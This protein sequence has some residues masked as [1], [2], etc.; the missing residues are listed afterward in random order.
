MHSSERPGS[1][2]CFEDAWAELEKRH[3]WRI[4]EEEARQPELNFSQL[5]Y[6]WQDYDNRFA[7]EFRSRHNLPAVIAGARDDWD[8]LLKLRHWTFTHLRFGLVPS[9]EMT[10]P[11]PTVIVE[12]SLAGGTFYCTHFAH[13]FV[14]A[15]AAMGYP[16]RKISVDCDHSESEES[17]QHGIADVW[18]NRFRKWVA[19]DS[20]FDAHY[21]ADGIPLNTE[22]IG[23]RW[24]THRGEGVDA[25]IGPDSRRV[26]RARGGKRDAP[27]ACS[28][29]WHYIN[30]QNDIFNRHARLW[31][32]PVVMPVDEA[33]RSKQWYSGSPPKMQ[34]LD[35]R[36]N[37]AFLVTE[38]C[39]DAYPDMNC[40]KL[41]AAPPSNMP[42]YCPVRLE[43]SCT[44][45]FSHYEIATDG[46][47]PLRFDGI[48]Y[49]WRLRTGVCALEA[50][51][52]NLAGHRGPP[53]RL[54]IR[55]EENPERKATWPGK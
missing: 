29:F 39:A 52:V 50:C 49:P 4:A 22:E 24:Q 15:A 34:A 30:C 27:E 12:A 14:A 42:Y 48:E 20:N 32:V 53:S 40:A 25:L 31:P 36:T 33:R 46:G 6:A 9:I 38:R 26:P 45:N 19:F 11:D 18:V 13:A 10:G 55:I 41:N 2:R 51:A 37:R 43:R 8:A 23:R 17:T 7:V 35:W 28:F 47:A 5:P 3:A 21:E 44:P 54:R 1:Q 16:A